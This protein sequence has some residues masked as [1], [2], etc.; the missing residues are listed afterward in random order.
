MSQAG[1]LIARAFVS[2]LEAS[3]AIMTKARPVPREPTAMVAR[4]EGQ[5]KEDWGS[6]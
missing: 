2:R 5:A 4:S 6:P 1:A 3:S